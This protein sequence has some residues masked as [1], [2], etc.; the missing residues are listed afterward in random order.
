MASDKKNRAS[1]RGARPWR[2]CGG[3]AAPWS[4]GKI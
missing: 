1:P 3:R 4:P 2:R